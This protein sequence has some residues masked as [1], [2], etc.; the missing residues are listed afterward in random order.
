MRIPFVRVAILFSVAGLSSLVQ[1]QITTNTQRFDFSVDGT[2]I[3]G[4]NGEIIDLHGT[5]H[6]IVNLTQTSSGF[7]SA[8]TISNYRDVTGV[9]ETTGAT[10]R[11]FWIDALHSFVFPNGQATFTT[12]DTLRMTSNGNA[13]N[14]ISTQMSVYSVR[15]DGT[16]SL[17]IQHAR[18]TCE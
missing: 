16:V 12:F 13:Q 4:C 3:A 6:S 17:S 7:I 15:A 18:A 14:S 9:G 10:Y 5:I 2:A 1:A 8:F 11:M